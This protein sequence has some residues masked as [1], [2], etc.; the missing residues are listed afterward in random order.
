MINTFLAPTQIHAP[1]TAGMHQVHPCA[2]CQVTIGC[3]LKCPS[4]QYQVPP[5][6]MQMIAMVEKAAAFKHGHK[7]FTALISSGSSSPALVGA[8]SQQAIFRM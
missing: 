2:S 8:K 4:T 3:N 1:P 7:L 6:I 5:R